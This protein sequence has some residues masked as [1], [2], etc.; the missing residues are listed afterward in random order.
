[1]QKLDI[2]SGYP[3]IAIM[4]S[5]PAIHLRA[6]DYEKVA[7]AWANRKQVTLDN[8]KD[9]NTLLTRVVKFDGP[10]IEYVDLAEPTQRYHWERQGGFICR[11]GTFHEKRDHCDC[12]P[13]PDYSQQRDSG[14]LTRT[15]DDTSAQWGKENMERMKTGM[16][17]RKS[18]LEAVYSDIEAQL[19]TRGLDWCETNRSKWE[20]Q[21][22]TSGAKMNMWAL[23]QHNHKSRFQSAVSDF[24]KAQKEQEVYD[25]PF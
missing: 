6:E 22:S 2:H 9:P 21:S 13:K 4:K 7:D 8:Y 1:M 10:S 17:K 16:D 18:E 15:F 20:I 5:G 24:E 25:L 19:R 3:F 12:R 14:L 11:F 23:F